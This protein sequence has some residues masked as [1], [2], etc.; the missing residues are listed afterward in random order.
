M[1]AEHIESLEKRIQEL[2]IEV[3]IWKKKAEGR[4]LGV[5]KLHSEISDCETWYDGC[6]CT[7][8]FLLNQINLNKDLE[9]KLE[10]CPPRLNEKFVPYHSTEWGELC[11]QGWTT[12]FVRDDGIAQMIPP[13][14]TP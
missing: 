9:A 1:S 3:E 4:I 10:P 8:D 14:R 13:Q 6:N 12:W 2:L 11:A 7:L 5:G